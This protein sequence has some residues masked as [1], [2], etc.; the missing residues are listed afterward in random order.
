VR[1]EALLERFVPLLIALSSALSFDLIS[2]AI[3]ADVMDRT[4]NSSELNFGAKAVR[5]PADCEEA[6]CGQSLGNLL[7]GGRVQ[8]RTTFS[9][10]GVR[11]DELTR[12]DTLQVATLGT[13]SSPSTNQFP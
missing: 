6:Q 11:S 5:F 8:V 2:A 1:T 12:I 9:T 13:P 10:S 7:K 4:V 3:V